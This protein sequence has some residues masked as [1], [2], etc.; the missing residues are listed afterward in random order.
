MISVLDSGLSGS[1]SLVQ[2]RAYLGLV[3]SALDFLQPLFAIHGTSRSSDV[4][5]WI[6]LYGPF[7][8]SLGFC[9]LSFLP[10][11]AKHVPF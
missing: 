9:S 8:I 2:S 7:A 11:S 6:Q 5:S 3:L 10:A 4:D 1:V